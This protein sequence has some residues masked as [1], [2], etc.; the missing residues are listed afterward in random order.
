MRTEFFMKS[1]KQFL[2]TESV[3]FNKMFKICEA[4][5][6]SI[7]VF[8]DLDQTS[9][10][11]MNDFL[12]VSG[13]GHTIV[14]VIDEKGRRVLMTKGNRADHK[15]ASRLL[16]TEAD[17]S[18]VGSTQKWR[19]VLV[20]SWHRESGQQYTAAAAVAAGCSCLTTFVELP[21]RWIDLQGRARK[22]L[23]TSRISTNPLIS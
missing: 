5:Q 18:Q 1:L 4:S 2:D 6:A 3:R 17:F 15:Q 9:I 12:Q 21:P 10:E 20:R 14:L 22:V 13:R 7:N 11:W 23:A 19:V 16:S 8:S